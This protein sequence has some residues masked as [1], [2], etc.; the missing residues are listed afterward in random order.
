M[1]PVAAVS[2]L[3]LAALI[4]SGV[5]LSR[6]YRAKNR[7]QSAC[8]AAV[9]AG[10]RAETNQGFDATARTQAV[11][12][13]Q[14]NFDDDRQDTEATTF[15]PYSDDDGETVK[16]RASTTSDNMIMKM[17]GFPEVDLVVDCQASMGVGNSDV[18]MVLDTTGS[19][20]YD[21]AGTTKNDYRINALRTAMKNFYAT[22]QTAT[23][24]TNARVRYGFVPYS[25]AVNVGKILLDTN[26]DYL[27]DNWTYQTRD[28]AYREVITQV[29]DRWGNE[30]VTVGT[31]SSASVGNPSWVNLSSATTNSN[32]CN[33]A[34]PSNTSWT[35][36]GKATVSAGVPAQI[37]GK[38]V[39]TYSSAQRQTRTAYRCYKSGNGNKSYV[40]QSRQEE[41][42]VT[43]TTIGTRDPIYRNVSTW[44]FDHWDYLERSRDTS[45][46]KLFENVSS[47][48][49]EGSGQPV[50]LTSR[51]TGCVQE[52]ETVPAS[53]F[54]FSSITG[55]TPDGAQDLDI[56]HIPGGAD[57]TR[58][59]PMWPEMTYQRKRISGSNS[60]LTT[61]P[62]TV[63]DPMTGT[64]S[65]WW[66]CPSPAKLLGE[67]SQSAFNAY[68]NSLTTSGGTYLDIGIAWGGRFLSPDGIFGDL[69]NEPPD[70][71][72][73]VSKHIIFMTDGDMA[74]NLNTLTSYGMEYFDRKTTPNGVNYGNNL[75]TS[76]LHA[77][78]D[79]TARHSSRFR[80]VC[81]AVRAKGIRIW[82]I[83]FKSGAPSAD[84]AACASD[85]S[86]FNAGNAAQLNAAF[87]E[88]AKQVGELRIV[89]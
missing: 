2:M 57:S 14:A 20:E 48:I 6:A 83:S 53:S 55:L 73:K 25:S 76:S 47:L 35:N 13:F 30:V 7:L 84:L 34:L 23:A 32:D 17:F 49:G 38:Q 19:M 77:N 65:T 82:T 15:A 51:W 62:T 79:D 67:M 78:S 81:K 44:V 72:A 85:A 27:A 29:F 42:I 9:L 4:G 74:P 64:N 31:V 86:S 39:T 59:G 18:I 71:G 3:L 11:N 36:V 26:P 16:A 69:V 88:I 50:N 61:A 5:D 54:S 63:G 56:D 68:A 43:S 66:P 52:P 1:L 10:R 33:A 12:F 89:H 21:M 28:P 41:Q 70:N 8:D 60:Y 22:L 75:V 46:F 58:W 37:N 87:Q 24:G 40:Q 45:R 80:A